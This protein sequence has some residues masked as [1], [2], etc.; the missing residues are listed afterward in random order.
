MAA[1]RA[2]KLKPVCQSP[3][4]L[5][6]PGSVAC[7]LPAACLHALGHP[8][9]PPSLTHTNAFKTHTHTK[10]R[11]AK[12]RI[13]THTNTTQ[14]HTTASTRTHHPPTC[15]ASLSVCLYAARQPCRV[16]PSIHRCVNVQTRAVM[17]RAR[18]HTPVMPLLACLLDCLTGG[19]FLYTH[20]CHALH[21]IASHPSSH[22]PIVP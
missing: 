18:T 16:H 15:H 11:E 13:H 2:A 22:A 6:P 4:S 7:P 9:T 17:W 1:A 3:V 21:G 19:S 20:T 14:L 8:H 10:R 12:E 5:S